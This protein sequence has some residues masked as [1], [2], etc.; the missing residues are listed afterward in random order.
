MN[1]KIAGIADTLSGPR[2]IARPR[3][4][5]IAKLGAAAALA[6]LSLGVGGLVSARCGSPGSPDLRM[7]SDSATPPRSAGNARFSSTVY[8][9]DA[10]TMF[11]AVPVSDERWD[12]RWDD[13][14][15]SPS[16]V[17]LWKF[18]WRDPSGNLVDF[19]LQEWHEDGTEIMNSGGRVPEVGD[20]CMGSWRQVGRST[21]HLTHLALGYGP[22]PGPAVGY[23]G[24]AV[25]D[26][27]VTVDPS[28]KTFH[29]SF[30]LTQYHNNFDPNTP[31][32]EFDQSAVDFSLGGSFTGVRVTP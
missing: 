4:T 31:N 12:E 20:V 17:G 29:G 7:P 15:H 32:S 11:R 27:Q 1:K 9:P 22:P 5:G 3:R 23:Q 24:L 14:Y 26:A 19:G 28:G 16:I 2:S 18:E 25:V 30:T 10:N 8:R 21:F 13:G 6:L